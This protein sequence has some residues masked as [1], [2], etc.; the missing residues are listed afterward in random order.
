MAAGNKKKKKPRA[1]PARGVATTSIESKSKVENLKELKSTD[2]SGTTTPDTSTPEAP[3]DVET[4]TSEAKRELHEMSPEELEA[5]LETS[6]LQQFVETHAARV[7]KDTLRH[8]SRLGTDKRILR[9]QA[10]FLSVK[11]WLPEGLMQLMFD[12]TLANSDD[13][14]RFGQTKSLPLGDDLVAKVWNLRLI[15]LGLDIP[16]ARANE[17][18]GFILQ[19]PPSEESTIQAWGL[20][21]ALD[22]LALNCD[23]GELLEYDSQR[24]HTTTEDEEDIGDASSDHGDAKAMQTLQ[25][26]DSTS[27][28]AKE[29][30]HDRIG[31][32]DMDVS[33][34]ESDLEPDE[35]LSVYLRTKESL[36][37]R[38]PSI[39][40][41]PTKK[42][43]S[44][45]STKLDNSGG[46]T[47]TGERKLH[48]K[49]QRIESDILFDHREADARWVA[50]KQTLTKEEAERR[51]FQLS[52]GNTFDGRPQSVSASRR[53]N[54]SVDVLDVAGGLGDQVQRENDYHDDNMLS[55]MFDALPGVSEMTTEEQVQ[56]VAEKVTI[57]DF[58]RVPAMTPRRILEESC[59]SRD[60]R[61]SITFKQVST[62]TYACRHS[63][64]ID[65]SKEQD[66]LD[67]SYVQSV[68]VK[69]KPR[70]LTVTMVREATLNVQQ[71]ESYVATVA[72]FLIFSG[73][74]KEEKSHLRLPP[75]YRDLWDEL[76]QSKRDNTDT[77][78][79]NTIK[80]LR[81][82][83]ATYTAV[84]TD[85]DDEVVFNA[86]SRR[87]NGS[88]S[89][90]S[91]P[92]SRSLT[93]APGA[94][95][96]SQDLKDLW[97]RK[98]AMPSYQHM[99]SARMNLPMSN[100][101]SN[102]LE[103][104][105]KNQVTILVS[106]TGSGKSTQ[107]PQFLLENELSQ[108]RQ[109]KIYCTQPRRIS[110]LSLAQ[111]G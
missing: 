34:I 8:V 7:R 39:E 20:V 91:T 99:L 58:G 64:A 110:A 66:R 55:G 36:Y 62:T 23:S 37:L 9:G 84:E 78:D 3:E 24:K 85:A 108:G 59:R 98:V 80:D 49:L 14:S 1:N 57:R 96:V 46:V 67:S 30:S 31:D 4:S 102:T 51:R 111:R 40:G 12:F 94:T 89:G 69:Y 95:E 76:L 90:N 2:A 52:N 73:S 16:I 77:A 71:S 45:T 105:E 11:D 83:I 70:H 54:N 25:N 97:A 50:K 10:D 47:T 48:Q 44:G 32:D 15:L 38:N 106:E 109:C 35:L 18:I 100:A 21:N 104:I 79:R 72:L 19:H 28:M 65:W 43:N 6:E 13:E 93:P 92:V 101:K 74:P 61:C 53:P 26:G 87:L 42:K 41:P 5:Q 81:D 75:V 29:D 68:G 17:A 63:V 82:L 107:L 103:T 60:Q 56:N 88:A 22:W 27:P 33:D 86:N